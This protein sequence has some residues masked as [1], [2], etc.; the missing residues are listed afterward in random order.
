MFKPSTT[1]IQPASLAD[2]VTG[3]VED[4]MPRSGSNRSVTKLD[5]GGQSSLSLALSLSKSVILCNL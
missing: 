1:D 4:A 5:G 3:H 2:A